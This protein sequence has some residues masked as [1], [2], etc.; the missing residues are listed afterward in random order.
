MNLESV[1][2]GS[3]SGNARVLA[4]VRATRG[5]ED[6]RADAFLIDDD[7]MKTVFEHLEDTLKSS[8]N[9]F[10]LGLWRERRLCRVLGKTAWAYI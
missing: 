8:S 3:V 9:R 1:F 6:Q 10:N 4:A 2:A 5:I 7:L